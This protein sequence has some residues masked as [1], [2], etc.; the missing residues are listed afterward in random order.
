T[1]IDSWWVNATG[2][3]YQAVADVTALVQANGSGPYR[4]SGVD[5]VNIIN[6]NDAN[7]FAGWWLA[8]FYQDNTQ[9]LRNLA[10]FDGLDTVIGGASQTVM[11]SGFLVPNSGYDAKLGVI[12][13]EGD[14]TLV[15]DS[16]IFNGVMKTDAQN[17]L[18]NFFN[19]TRSYLGV[20]ASQTM[21]L[22]NMGDLP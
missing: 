19:G 21:P 18:N 4:V 1:A 9:P 15:G 3:I 5:A 12:T 14:N 10:L 17:P 22:N 7:T 2:G 16:L 11:L 13:Y 20:A 8:A 6:L